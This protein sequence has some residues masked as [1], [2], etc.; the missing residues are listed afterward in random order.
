MK[1]NKILR[2]A[3]VMLMLCLITTCA[4]SGTFAK[5][6]TSNDATDSARVA[7][8]GVGIAIT[9]S[10]EGEDEVFVNEYAKDA[11]GFDGITNTVV[12]ASEDLVAPGTTGEITIVLTGAPEVAFDFQVAVDITSD[13]VV[14]KNTDVGDTS[15]LAADYNPVKFTLKKDGVVVTGAEKITLAELETKLEALSGAKQANDTT[16]AATYTITWEWAF[17]GN[18]YADTYLG[19]VA[20][21]TVT[22]ANTKTNI[23]FEITVSATQID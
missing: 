22:D 1:K 20:A 23:E 7:K 19:N 10:T 11:S 15:V 17:S 3:S 21:G 6:T 14:P 12:H 5:Y 18:D 8:W 4:I 2:L 13:V 9:A 16:F